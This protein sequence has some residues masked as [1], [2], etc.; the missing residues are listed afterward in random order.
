MENK[1]NCFI[2]GEELIYS[3]SYKKSECAICKMSFEI[4][5]ECSNSHYVCDSCHSSSANEFIKTFCINRVDINP[6]EMAETI[7]RHPS[8]KMHGPEHHFLVPAVLLTA[9]FNKTGK[10]EMI[11]EK[12]EI[13]EKRAKNVL[14][15]FCGFYGNCGAAVGTGIFTSIITDTTP[16]S[17][18]S[19]GLSNKATATSLMQIAEHDGPRCC[20]RDTFISLLNMY[21]F[22]KDNFDIELARSET[23][24][25]E[26]SDLNKECKKELCNFY[27]NE[28]QNINTLYRQ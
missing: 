9:F 14:G 6:V 22:I 15:G 3:T 23:I 17:G 18:K 4:N 5:V 7:M 10:H 21:D 26:F 11:S 19:W 13:A 2:C 1:S 27:V 24:K 12:L 20:K 16:L 25:C 8:V 28:N